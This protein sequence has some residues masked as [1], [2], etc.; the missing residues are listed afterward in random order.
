MKLST[1]QRQI[2]KKVDRVCYKLDKNPQ[3]RFIRLMR[4]KEWR[5]AGEGEMRS[6]RVDYMTNM[7]ACC[8]KQVRWAAIVL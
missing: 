1:F 2:D 6:Y 8:K 4:H 7:R 3:A 5:K